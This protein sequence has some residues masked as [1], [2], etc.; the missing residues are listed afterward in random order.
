MR[1]LEFAESEPDDIELDIT[2]RSKIDQVERQVTAMGNLL[3]R[4][5]QQVVN[6]ILDA[7]DSNFKH[8]PR[9]WNELLDR[10]GDFLSDYRQNA[11]SY[12]GEDVSSELQE[13][14]TSANYLVKQ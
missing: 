10:V 7:A 4:F 5:D 12:L 14:L 3:T 11:D 6:Q 13:M 2:D 1:S 9:N 8:D